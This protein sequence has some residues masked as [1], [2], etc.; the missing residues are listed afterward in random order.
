[1]EE[2]RVLR[3]RWFDEYLGWGHNRHVIDLSLA[4]ILAELRTLRQLGWTKSQQEEQLDT[5][6]NQFWSPLLAPPMLDED[7]EPRI[8]TVEN[9][10]GQI[11]LRLLQPRG[12]VE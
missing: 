12:N 1:M 10:D 3:C 7:E 4:Y 11:F 9:G 2:S 6:D 8:L 5:V